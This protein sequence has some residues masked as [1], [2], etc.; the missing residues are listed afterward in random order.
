[1]LLNKLRGILGQKI[2]PPTWF[3]HRKRTNDKSCIIVQAT[4]LTLGARGTWKREATC[5][6][7][8]GTRKA[9]YTTNDTKK[10]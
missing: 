8:V 3:K 6:D 2:A 1:M 9:L 10:T 4:Q 7:C 5:T